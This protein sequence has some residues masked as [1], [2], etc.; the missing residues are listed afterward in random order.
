[1]SGE[2]W[3]HVYSDPESFSMYATKSWQY[4]TYDPKI[5]LRK[6]IFTLFLLTLLNVE[7]KM[8]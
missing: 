6:K 7:L 3:L 4:I 2:I 8:V 5:D 1:M